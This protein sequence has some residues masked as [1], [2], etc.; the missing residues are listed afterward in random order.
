MFNKKINDLI[1]DANSSLLEAMKKMDSIDRKLLLVFDKDKFI[2][3]VSI[4]DIQRALIKNCSINSPV[5]DSLR[6]NTRIA[7]IKDEVSSIKKMMYDYRNEI[8]PV[9]DDVPL[10]IPPAK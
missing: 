6:K 2:N 1:I 4:G 5:K 7:N 3:L 9:I 8:M 10:V